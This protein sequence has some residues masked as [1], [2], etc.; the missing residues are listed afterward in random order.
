MKSIAWREVYTAASLNCPFVSWMAG[1]GLSLSGCAM[2]SVWLWPVSP[3]TPP[4]FESWGISDTNNVCRPSLSPPERSGMSAWLY[5]RKHFPWS[6][7]LGRR[8]HVAS[9][10]VRRSDRPHTPNTTHRRNPASF[11]ARLHLFEYHLKAS[12]GMITKNC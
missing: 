4:W 10:P 8:Q 5:L 1:S 7:H 11:L 6:G 12:K 9:N 2:T 3:P